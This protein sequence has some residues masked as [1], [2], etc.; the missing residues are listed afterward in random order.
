MAQQHTSLG[1]ALQALFL[2]EPAPAAKKPCKRPAVY[3]EAPETTAASLLSPAQKATQQSIASVPEDGKRGQH[4]KNTAFNNPRRRLDFDQDENA[5]KENANKEN[6]NSAADRSSDG[7]RCSLGRSGCR[8][9]KPFCESTCEST[10]TK[11]VIPPPPSLGVRYQPSNERQIFLL[12]TPVPTTPVHVGRF[13]SNSEPAG[14]K[15]IPS[16]TGDK[17]WDWQQTAAYRYKQQKTKWNLETEPTQKSTPDQ[18]TDIQQTRRR[19]A[20]DPTTSRAIVD[21]A[22]YRTRRPQL[23]F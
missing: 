1:A 16:V 2:G 14:K 7:R 23:G 5:N 8:T 12:S 20:T 6:V 22:L 17:R 10:M 18:P 21:R 15:S 19:A 11:Q 13:R 4:T 9:A 3:S